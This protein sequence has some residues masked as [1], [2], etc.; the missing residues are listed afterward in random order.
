MIRTEDL[1]RLSIEEVGKQ[2]LEMTSEGN[3]LISDVVTIILQKGVLCR[4]SDI[5]MT[6]T[7]DG[8]RIRY[9]ID[10]LF[11]ELVK[12]PKELHEQVVSRTKV[13]AGLMSHKRD[14]IQ[15]GRIT[16]TV[17]KKGR[18]L[19]LSVIPT[20]L[21]EKMV[22][23][24]FDPKQALIELEEL[25]YSEELLK[26]YELLL[27]DLQGMIILTGP[28]GSGKTTTLYSSLYKISTDL[29]Q[30]ASIVT[31]EDPVEYT[32]GRFAQM[33]VSRIHGIDFISGLAAIL[34]QDPQVIMVGEIRD[35]ETCEVALRAGLT[36]HLILTTIHSGT[37]YDVITRLLNMGI[38]PF[39]IASAVTGIM[40]QRLVRTLC[41]HC[42]QPYKPDPIKL[43]YF[44]QIADFKGVDFVRGEG[45]S[46]CNYTGFKGRIP[47]AE[48][49]VFNEKIRQFILQKAPSNV[50]RNFVIQ[51]GMQTFLHDGIR[52][53]KEGITTVEEVFRAVSYK[54]LSDIIHSSQLEK[55]ETVKKKSDPDR[56]DSLEK[57]VFKP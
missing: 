40:A 43:Q 35:S 23:R 45:C 2:L 30:Y 47:I 29:D 24:I 5:H 44:Q 42:K 26:E 37:S 25:G 27:F 33:Q 18:D 56:Q 34:R 36:G 17:D 11:Q 15:E 51:M 39:V 16:I 54:E 48:L 20:V 13:V 49:L 10:G 14:I 6:P 21:G 28:S 7:R 4:A 19:R 3:Y 8:L 41:S 12:L 22:I 50:I 38:E 9:R 53:I 31:L 52:K 1:K 55:E 46:K 57:G 32:V